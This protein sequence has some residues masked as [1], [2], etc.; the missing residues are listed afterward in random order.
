MSGGFMRIIGAGLAGLIAG[1]SYQNVPI[2]EPM[3]STK[4]H[5]A[6]LRFRSPDIGDAVGIPFKQVKVYKGIWDGDKYIKLNPRAINIYSLKVANNCSYR[7]IIHQEPEQR[8][9]APDD[10]QERLLDMCSHRIEYNAEVD[11]KSNEATISTIPLPALASKL[12]YELE[13]PI[14]SISKIYVSTCIVGD[15]NVYMTCYN[16]NPNSTIYRSSI[17]G[18]KLIIESMKPIRDDHLFN[19]F[20]SLGVSDAV[21]SEFDMNQEVSNGKLAPIDD[22]IR[23]GL[24]LQATM[25]YNIYSLGRFAIWKNIVLDEVYQDLLKIKK[26]MNN[27]YNLVRSS[28]W[29]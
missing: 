10:F 18:N 17:T 26:F 5:T 12:G 24:I 22:R 11:Y 8:W 15:C 13:M 20:Q 9:I 19:V 27:P 2:L 7:S 21:I 1:T 4:K 16:V 23:K 29:M 6:L 14:G 25:E 3:S 28:I